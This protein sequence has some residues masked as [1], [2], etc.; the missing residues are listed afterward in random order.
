MRKNA[1]KIAAMMLSLALT[2]TSVNVPTTSSAASKVTLNKTKATLYVGGASSKKTTT[3]K[4]TFNGKK[5]SATFTSSNAKVAKVAKKTGKVTAVKAGSATITAKYKSKKATCKI[6]VKQYV[7]GITAP[8]SIELTEGE[9]I[10]LSKQVT[11]K[12]ANASNKTI[13][14]SP[15]ES[16]IAGVNKDGTKLKGVKAG[17]TA[18]TIKAKDGSNKQATVAVTVKA[19]PATETEAPATE[20]PATETPAETE[21]PATTE[22]PETTPEATVNP[23]GLKSAVAKDAK[24]LTITLNDGTEAEV[25]LD[26][27]LTRGKN[28]VNFQ[29]EGETY[30]DVEVEYKEQSGVAVEVTGA[31]ARS[32]NQVTVTLKDAPLT[33]LKAD[34]FTITPA[35]NIL[36]VTTNNNI[37]SLTTDD[38]AKGTEY[39][40]VPANGK[41]SATF[42]ASEVGVTTGVLTGVKTLNNRELE[43]TFSTPLNV[44]NVTLSNTY[45]NMMEAADKVKRTSSADVEARSLTTILGANAAN[46]EIV[47]TNA[48]DGFATVYKVRAK[49]GTAATDVTLDNLD[50]KYNENS[51]FEV[52]DAKDSTGYVTTSQG[53]FTWIDTDAPTVSATENVAHKTGATPYLYVT[54]NEPVKNFKENSEMKVYIDGN[55]IDYTKL[56]YGVNAKLEADTATKDIVMNESVDQNC[57]F[58]IDVSNY[59]EDTAHTLTIVGAQ[60]LKGNV[61]GTNPTELSFKVTTDNGDDKAA[62]YTA[63]TVNSVTQVADNALRVQ[64]DRL[65]KPLSNETLIKIEDCIYSTTAAD[66]WDNLYIRYN[67]TD[68]QYAIASDDAAAA[69]ASYATAD[70]TG[71]VAIAVQASGPSDAQ[72][73]DMV[74]LFNATLDAEDKE[75]SYDDSKKI[76]REITVKNFY[77]SNVPAGKETLYLNT[78]YNVKKELQHDIDAPTTSKTY[79]DLTHG[80]LYVG[81]LDNPFGGK[82]QLASSG[83]IKISRT[84][85]DSTTASYVAQLSTDSAY[86]TVPAAP[87]MDGSTQVF[88]AG[89][90]VKIDLAGLKSAKKSVDDLL[91]AEN[92]LIADSTYTVSFA[93]NTV[94]DIDGQVYT[95]GSLT[96][97]IVSKH[98]TGGDYNKNVAVAASIVVPKSDAAPTALTGGVP[99]ALPSTVLSGQDILDAAGITYA[100]IVDGSSNVTAVA[101]A[102][103]STYASATDTLYYGLAQ[104]PNAENANIPGTLAYMVNHPDAILVVFDTNENGNAVNVLQSSAIK[105]GNYT[106]NGVA[107]SA[108]STVEY[109]E[110]DIADVAGVS[111]LETDAI[112]GKEAYT[113]VTL[114]DGDVAKSGRYTFSVSGV[115]NVAGKAMLPV[116]DSLSLTD[117]T[118]PKAQYY[119]FFSTKEIDITFNEEIKIT[120]SADACNNFTITVNNNVY[121]VTSVTKKS[122][123]TLRVKVTSDFVTTQGNATVSLNKDN[124]GHMFITD[125]SPLANE[126]AVVIQIPKQ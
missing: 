45:I 68:Y 2:V 122:E 63:P 74:I 67:G 85:T 73:T 102:L 109:Y 84:G 52:R 116:S 93:K 104:S 79:F 82:I 96:D 59:K 28:I 123:N 36:S 54:F 6:T 27:T 111:Y 119:S 107:L 43:L 31:E 50:L 114:A 89:R 120:S 92:K 12:P 17:T 53:T 117:N 49:S 18:I 4:A 95:I 94:S 30:K 78:V 66:N 81:F 76:I 71:K 121:T 15:D 13:V 112:N 47:P 80:I 23:K 46:W 44:K 35:L 126:A 58:A 9:T 3:L 29:Y 57:K 48:A 113:I 77:S 69:G 10:D 25:T 87:L 16:Y 64:F 65:V 97:L 70:G 118:A 101:S 42:K 11:V 51:T 55:E 88:D 22:A 7:T 21:A 61:L 125:A 90:Y 110:N 37:V 98:V 39:T 124:N 5:V 99:Q 106:F 41:G 32:I 38:Q 86:I 75:F 105:K 56:V 19:A 20:A 60:D 62:V 1:T 24:T 14:Y 33:E 83:E 26:T 40:I 8:A 115:T 72:Y 103:K 108:N 91:T 100:A 34:D